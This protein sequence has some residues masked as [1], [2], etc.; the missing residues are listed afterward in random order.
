MSIF[1]KVKSRDSTKNKP[2]V[3]RFYLS[4]FISSAIFSS[5]VFAQDVAKQ[6]N[7]NFQ[8]QERFIQS[9]VPVESVAPPVKGIT[10]P[11]SVY[12]NYFQSTQEQLLVLFELDK[13]PNQFAVKKYLTTPEVFIGYPSYLNPRIS[14]SKEEVQKAKGELK[15][16]LFDFFEKNKIKNI[17]VSEDEHFANLFLIPVTSETFVEVSNPNVRI[18]PL[19]RSGYENVLIG[20]KAVFFN[21]NIFQLNNAGLK[22]TFLNDTEG[23]IVTSYCP[24]D[25]QKSAQEIKDN[26][27]YCIV[28][29]QGFPGFFKRFPT[30]D[31]DARL[32]AKNLTSIVGCSEVKPKQNLFDLDFEKISH[33]CIEKGN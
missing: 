1:D 33:Q 16:H 26:I 32:W 18:S 11:H 14:P 4:F 13:N 5:V 23:R 30:V 17:K 6:P 21:H 9:I 25:I 10:D 22:G 29:S 19:K 8:I 20:M 3:N 31:E 27:F 12:K 7:Q 2:S 15:I 24:V 28:Q